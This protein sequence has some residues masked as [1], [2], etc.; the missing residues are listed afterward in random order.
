MYY[1]GANRPRPRKVLTLSLTHTHTHTHTH[2]HT[3]TRARAHNLQARNAT[4]ERFPGGYA[5][6]AARAV[7]PGTG[8]FCW[9]LR[10]ALAGGGVGPPLD[11]EAVLPYIAP[12]A[13]LRLQAVLGVRV[14]TLVGRGRP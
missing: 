5:T 6:E 4:A 2:A 3:P 13:S 14:A 11:H 1:C 9:V 12:G 8:V 10:E 7:A